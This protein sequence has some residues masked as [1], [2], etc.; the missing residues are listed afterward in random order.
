VEVEAMD[1]RDIPKQTDGDPNNPARGNATQREEIKVLDSI[2]AIRQRPEMYIGKDREA[3][4]NQLIEP[5]VDTLLRAGARHI[6][7]TLQAGNVVTITDDGPGLPTDPRKP[8]KKIPFAQYLLTEL[9][10]GYGAPALVFCNALSQWLELKIRREGYHWEQDYRQGR[11]QGELHM[12][13]P[14][15]K[16]GN[17]IRFVPDPEIFAGMEYDF[18]KV[19]RRFQERAS[20]FEQILAEGEPFGWYGKA[21]HDLASL[22]QSAHVTIVDERP[23]ASG[24]DQVPCVT[25][26]PSHCKGS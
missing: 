1:D 19:V 18:D 14:T 13:Y 3:G 15:E 20:E 2:E 4:L 24:L 10:V 16:H 22:F 7:I 17:S 8:E 26:G 25:F 12:T 11:P 6:K 23:I 5:T 21:Q 9:L